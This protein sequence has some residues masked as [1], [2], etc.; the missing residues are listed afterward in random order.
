MGAPSREASIPYWCWRLV[1][2]IRLIFELARD[3]VERGN[4]IVFFTLTVKQKQTNTASSLA[5][6]DSDTAPVLFPQ[7]PPRIHGKY[8][9]VGLASADSRRSG[10]ATALTI[11]SFF[12]QSDF[13]YMILK[14]VEKVRVRV[15][16]SRMQVRRFTA[17]RHRESNP[18][19][20]RLG[21]RAPYTIIWDRWLCN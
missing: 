21:S 11:L 10:A 9:D 7:V 13:R 20:F 2:G 18:G 14:S 6:S 16:C 15:S 17:Y 19:T 12:F 3:S 4:L 5:L 1:T 8:F